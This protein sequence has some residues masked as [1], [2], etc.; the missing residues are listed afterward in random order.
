MAELLTVNPFIAS[1]SMPTLSERQPDT[2]P[3]PPPDAASTPLMSSSQWRPNG[4]AAVAVPAAPEAPRVAVDV[5]ME[6]EAA[7]DAEYRE[8]ESAEVAW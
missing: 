3:V 5:N 2:H 1:P 4:S 7:T 8:C 6:C